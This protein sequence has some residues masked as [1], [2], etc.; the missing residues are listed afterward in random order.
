MVAHGITLYKVATKFAQSLHFFGCFRALAN[1]G[2]AQALSQPNNS[3]EQFPGSCR[4]IYASDENAINFQL[5]EWQLLQISK[6]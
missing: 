2:H 1:N 4:K 3:L 6:R 5:G